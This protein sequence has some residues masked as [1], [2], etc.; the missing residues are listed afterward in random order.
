MA[1]DWYTVDDLAQLNQLDPCSPWQR[2]NP[3]GW[4]V[5]KW[6]AGGPAS[7]L[8]SGVSM[9]LGMALLGVVLVHLSKIELLKPAIDFV[10]KSKAEVK[11][12]ANR[13][14]WRSG[15]RS[16]RRRY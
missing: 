7:T 4:C 3:T 2:M 12:Y 15:R 6:W 1:K 16:R 8:I 10:K 13:R 5:D 14:K 9:A 11:M